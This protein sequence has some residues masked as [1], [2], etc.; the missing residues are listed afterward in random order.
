MNLEYGAK[1]NLGINKSTREQ[2]FGFINH[3]WT[4]ARAKT[5]FVSEQAS[6]NFRV[7]PRKVKDFTFKC[8]HCGKRGHIQA[9]CFYFWR[10]EE[11]SNPEIGKKVEIP[12]CSNYKENVRR[13]EQCWKS[14]NSAYNVHN[15][16]KKPSQVRMVIRGS[17]ESNNVDVNAFH[18]FASHT[19]CDI[20][21]SDRMK[22]FWMK[23]EDIL[24]YV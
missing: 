4:P 5:I 6:Q 8:Y 22:T 1:W 7:P 12:T 24:K 18:A 20:S 13:S 11:E 9:E 3:K 16:R 2:G 19:M 17:H 21:E 15:L 23:K 10:N 14:E